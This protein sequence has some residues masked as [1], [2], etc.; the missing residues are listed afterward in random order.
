VEAWTTKDQPVKHLWSSPGAEL[1]ATTGC[2]NP[3]WPRP[4]VFDSTFGG[5]GEGEL[6][7]VE[8]RG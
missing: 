7:D 6:E 4:E 3:S 2:V 8:E 5:V 1:K